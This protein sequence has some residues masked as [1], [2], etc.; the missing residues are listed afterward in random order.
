[1][2]TRAC[3]NSGSV[4]RCKVRITGAQPPQDATRPPVGFGLAQLGG[5]GFRLALGDL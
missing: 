5:I 2:L 1:M 3:R 4:S